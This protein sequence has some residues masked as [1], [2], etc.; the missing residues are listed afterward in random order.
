MKACALLF[1]K[2]AV[3][4]VRVLLPALLSNLIS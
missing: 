2:A 1:V 3:R 4:L